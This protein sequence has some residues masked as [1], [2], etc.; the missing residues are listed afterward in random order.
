[1]TCQ[2]CGY[3]FVFDPKKDRLQGRTL[4]DKLMQSILSTASAGQS[5]LYTRT[6]LYVF[7]CTRYRQLNKI[8]P[9]LAVAIIILSFF[10]GIVSGLYIISMLG[11]PAVAIFHTLHRRKR[12]QRTSWDA[13]LKRWEDAGHPLPHL[14]PDNALQAPPPDWEEPDIYDYGA[15]GLLLCQDI[16]IA[17]WFVLNHLPANLKLV[18]LSENGYPAYLVPVVIRLLADHPEL[19]IYLLHDGSQA[20][21]Q[22]AARLQTTSP[23]PLDGHPIFSLGIAPDELTQLPSRQVFPKNE[24]QAKQA[25]DSI[26][27]LELVE[28]IT[29]A[30]STTPPQSLSTVWISRRGR[31][32]RSG[33]TAADD[34]DFG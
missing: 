30:I 2:S 28:L 16:D 27:Y 1:M 14:L 15:L 34:G 8:S 31:A 4:T 10:A 7:A 26:P 25:L 32:G 5:L 20:G 3:N 22:M 13:C 6:Q 23:I 33:L 21:E 19:P 12:L 24:L 29:E 9:I 18:I 11:V 17:D